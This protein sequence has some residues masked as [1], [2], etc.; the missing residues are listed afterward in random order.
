MIKAHIFIKIITNMPIMHSYQL[1]FPELQ[2]GNGSF[3][4]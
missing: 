2:T 1:L 4:M 3:P